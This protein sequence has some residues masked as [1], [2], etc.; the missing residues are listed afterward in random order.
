MFENIYYFL[1]LI[2]IL[3]I[4]YSGVLFILY[5]FYNNLCRLYIYYVEMHPY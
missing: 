5:T 1:I 3:I 4:E 2:I